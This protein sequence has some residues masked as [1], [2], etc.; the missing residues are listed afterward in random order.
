MV[1]LIEDEVVHEVVNWD[2]NFI[3][4]TINVECRECNQTLVFFE[5]FK[6]SDI[7]EERITSSSNVNIWIGT[8]IFGANAVLI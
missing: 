1:Q 4:P 3:Q 2:I 6:I 5:N 7:T 8:L